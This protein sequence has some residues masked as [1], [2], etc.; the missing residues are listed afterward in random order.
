MAID[1]EA[2][3]KEFGGV[4]AE[5]GAFRGI[6]SSMVE[7]PTPAPLTPAP[8]APAPLT[9]APTPVD[10]EAMAAEFGG[11]KSQES[12]T[13]A[14]ET[15]GGAAFGVYPRTGVRTP[16]TETKKPVEIS[17]AKDFSELDKVIEAIKP[18]RE[19][20]AVPTEA[21]RA[22]TGGMR[23]RGQVGMP[24]ETPDKAYAKI[25]KD[26]ITPEIAA[27][28]PEVV[29][30]MGE[31]MKTR[32]P[33]K[34]LSKNPTELATQFRD[35]FIKDT[36]DLFN[37]TTWILN[38]TPEQK[39][40]AVKG[41]ELSK[42]MSG[43]FGKELV[44]GLKDPVN[45]AG[46]VGAW[47]VK[48]GMLRG[49]KSLATIQLRSALTAGGVSG[50]VAGGMNI[51]EQKNQINLGLRDEISYLE[52]TANFVVVGALEGVL[53]GA[54]VSAGGQ[55]TAERLATA[56]AGK[57]S[58][59]LFDKAAEDF[60]NEFIK[61]EKEI[62]SGPAPLYESA[63][64]RQEAREA[65]LDKA[66]PPTDVYQAVLTKPIVDDIF[67]VARELF[68]I[69]PDLR[70]NLN[71][72]RTVEGIVDALKV[73]GSDDIQQAS[74]RAGVKPADFLEM[75]KVQAS[76]AGA[77]L[78]Q[79]KAMSD[80]LRKMTKG[81]PELEK[82]FNRMINAGVGTDQ[83]TFID[84]I[85]SITGKS[86]ALM[87]SSLSTA[88]QNAVSLMGPIPLQTGVDA[89]EAVI[90][91]AGRM[92]NDLS[93]KGVPINAT[94]VKEETGRVLADSGFLLSKI[95]DAGYTKEVAN[96]LLI[97]NPRL[98]N[99]VT[100]IGVD[101]DKQVGGMGADFVNAV[102]IFNRAVDGVVRAPIYVSSL[103]KRMDAVG[104][105]YEDFLANNKPIPVSVSKAAVDDMMKLTFTYGFK[106]TAEKGIEGYSENLAFGTLDRINK[107]AM[108]GV[109]KDIFLPFVRFQLN[110]VRFTYRLT[111][112]SG[113]GA[114]KELQEAAALRAQ[115]KFAEA[116]GVAYSAKT[117]AIES[118]IGSAAIIGAIAYRQTE[119]AG[120][121]FYQRRDDDGNIKDISA[122][123]PFVNIM[124][125]AEAVLVMKDLAKS[126]SQ[127]LWYTLKMTPEQRA[128]EAKVIKAKADALDNNDPTKQQLINEY[129][130]LR[131]GR[132]RS[133]DGAKFTE[134]MTGMGR[135]GGV[136][137]TL[138]DQ[139]KDMAEGGITD[140]M[141]AKAGK[142]VGDFV[143]R[144]DNFMNPIWDTVNFLRDDMRVVDPKAST[145]LPSSIPRSVESAIATVAAPVPFA[146][147]ILESR[148]SLFQ[149]T[150]PQVPTV[151]RQ[152]AMAQATPTTAVESELTR[153]GIKPYSV[154]KST[155][156][157]DYD[158]LRITLARPTF[159][160]RIT[161]FINTPAYKQLSSEGKRDAIES[162]MASVLKSTNEAASKIFIKDF[163][164]KAVN[165]LYEK[166]PNRKSQE[167]YF[168]ERFDRRPETQ[169]EKMAVINGVFDTAKSIGK[170]R[171]GL[172]ARR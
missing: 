75:F 8:A 146:R 13:P 94:R 104:L 117:K 6:R 78:Q 32:Y 133:F 21:Q 147:D 83:V 63:V 57:K 4:P 41:L 166:A 70:P 60:K 11:K 169:L 71:E 56:Q 122:A 127:S 116:A 34:L 161:D 149:K 103:K 160:T 29:D 7:R 167:D 109:A 1:Y 31:Y 59:E 132:I 153:L 82:V 162:K 20:R 108:L 156:N 107:N 105:N 77:F 112:F 135:S 53:S 79:A 102:T 33:N 159:I 58:P 113:M 163:G 67:K 136:Q 148:P 92:V 120:H 85:K 25:L 110:A 74:I 30:F 37:E 134:I 64:A 128:T 121:E 22:I 40:I 165:A 3:A 106:D 141:E 44:S 100:N 155:G 131:L 68:N 52:A 15:A 10:Y 69:R 98:N 138:I 2:L 154:L 150:E 86:V 16:L 47:A 158:N 123:F 28:S 12:I 139:V 168:V 54:T 171:G 90:K 130:L 124:A 144:Y 39:Q 26:K 164:E 97:Q 42:E 96:A 43:D 49:T 14:V 55:K 76:E 145:T 51:V 65:T 61:K 62:T 151:T 172:V 23:V 19:F 27:K 45:Y 118:E 140:S 125:I 81:D 126:Q 143:G 142:Y 48:Q 66:V 50:T 87:T 5:E 36:A 46:G 129:E 170:A 73:A 99:L 9:S 18:A 80:V 137:R 93:G 101:V 17:T 95:V 91:S 84:K 119:G 24:L 72:V 35:S 111:P 157:K 152:I 38:A 88:A 89:V 114:Y 115:G